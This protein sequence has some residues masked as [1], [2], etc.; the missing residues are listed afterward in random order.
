M[1]RRVR[2][3][4]NP[5]PLAI[6]IAIAAG[7]A[8][9]TGAVVYVATR[10]STTASAA[11]STGSTTASTPTPPPP[12]TGPAITTD[13]T[14]VSTAA[15]AAMIHQSAVAAQTAAA[16]AAH[17]ATLTNTTYQLVVS[18]DQSI[19]LVVG[20]TVRIIPSANGM[21]PIPTQWVYTPTG[22]AAN[23]AFVIQELGSTNGADAT[24]QAMAAGSANLNVKLVDQATQQTVYAVYNV[25]VTV[26]GP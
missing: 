13:V 22:D 11:T 12:L 19:L 9:A 7:A 10:P 26:T 21:P 20:N 15:N 4:E 25:T 2:V 14:P 17:L 6:W 24:F 18:G 16:N 3:R 23:G 8:L 1:R 5:L